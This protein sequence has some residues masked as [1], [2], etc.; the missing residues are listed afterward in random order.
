MTPAEFSEVIRKSGKR[1]YQIGGVYYLSERLLCYSFPL[2]HKYSLNSI[3]QKY[4]RWRSL[5][6]IIN[7]D[8]KSY[9]T[10]EFI[11][12]SNDYSIDSFE[13]K[14][15]NRIR[16]SIELLRFKV[17]D[18]GDLIEEGLHI[19]RKTLKLQRRKDS[20]LTNVNKW[21]KYI[22]ILH[23]H[24]QFSFFG[25][26]LHDKMIAYIV[27]C[28]MMDSFIIYHA[29]I[30]KEQ[31][32]QACP[33][34]GL[35]YYSVNKLIE[36]YGKVTISY[37]IKSFKPL[38][39]LDRFKA[40]MLFKEQGVSRGYLL[41]PILLTFVKLYLLVLPDCI[42]NNHCLISITNQ[43]ESLYQGHKLLT[44]KHKA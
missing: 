6:T 35:L 3:N 21:R 4:L 27:I 40:N 7:L 20:F 33:M 15:K 23:S 1:I 38:P 13:R 31:A 2:L 36:E 25:A 26:Y 17:P 30:D 41:H 9:N 32:S 8:L 28:K 14:V 29:F 5:I 12:S 37:G 44:E 24:K 39:N 22:T 18:I 19:N 16:K 10:K 11:L 34:N 42:K 43:I